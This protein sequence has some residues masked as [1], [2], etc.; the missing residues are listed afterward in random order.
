EEAI[1]WY[2][3]F[4]EGKQGWVE[5]NIAACSRKS[6]CYA[7][8]DNKE[9]TIRSLLQTLEYTPPRPDFCCQLA[10]LFANAKRY[11]EAIYWYSQ[12]LATSQYNSDMS[13]H[14][15][16]SATWLPH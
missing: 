10:S 4:L 8:L 9:M 11:P 3:L 12:A 1:K 5:D 14:N 13:F 6:K 2:D 7:Q 16:A 15:P